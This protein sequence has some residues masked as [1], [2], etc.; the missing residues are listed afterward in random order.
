MCESGEL[1]ETVR[2]GYMTQAHSKGLKPRTTKGLLVFTGEKQKRPYLYD[3][4]R[5]IYNDLLRRSGAIVFSSCR[6]GEFSYETDKIQNG[7]F[8]EQLI[9]AITGGHVDV[10]NDGVI[11]IDELRSYV[12][13]VVAEDTENLQHPTVDRDNIYQKFDFPILN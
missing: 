6:G 5:Y 2:N 11:S 12:I 13:K 8:T 4:D 10:N 7:F 3:R 1:D 9:Q